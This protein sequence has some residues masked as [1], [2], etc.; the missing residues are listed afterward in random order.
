MT[1]EDT[2]QAKPRPMSEAPRDGT[3]ILVFLHGYPSPHS[4]S[5]REPKAFGVYDDHDDGMIGW[6]VG[7]DGTK[8]GGHLLRGWLPCPT[9]TGEA[10]K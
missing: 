10:V 6:R 2:T 1:T 5:W 4:M 8:L 3:V 9:Y 7:W